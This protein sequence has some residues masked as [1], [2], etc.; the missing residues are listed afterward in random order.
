MKKRICS[1]VCCLALALSTAASLGGCEKKPEQLHGPETADPVSVSAEAVDEG[2]AALADFSV[3]LFQ[4]NV[5]RGENTLISPLSVLYALAMTANGAEGE[6]LVQMERVLGMPVEE[7]N[8]CLCAYAGSL[9]SGEKARLYL[10]NS[11]WFK[12]DGL[13]VEPDFLQANE[14]WYGASLY[15]APFDSGTLR[16]INNWIDKSTDGMI[17]QMLD[18]IPDDVAM[19]LI[20]ALTF[21]GEWEQIYRE[22]EVRKGTFTTEDGKAQDVELMY[23]QENRYLADENATGFIKYYAGKDYALAALLPNEGVSVEDYAASLSGEYLTALLDGAAA[24]PVETA[25]PKFQYGYGVEMNGQLEEMGMTDAFS[26][27][28]DFSKISGQT[29]LYISQVLHKTAI[30]VDEKGTKAGAATA[31]AMNS[32]AA[33]IP[34]KTVYLNRPFVYMLV[35]CQTNLPVFMGV[36]ADMG[37]QS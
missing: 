3:R 25:I 6:T 9:P 2:R 19:Y 36:L 32:S 28:A 35:D 24:D 20:N 5:R 26:P 4:K 16:D 21:D 1:L 33:V 7:L 27:A 34:L 11:I 29:A 12:D 30:T 15:K 13:T 22:N 8:Q 31:V 14:D 23:A 10:A 37:A 18:E 17:P